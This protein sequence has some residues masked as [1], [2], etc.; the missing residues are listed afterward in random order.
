M[1]R[2]PR[3]THLLPCFFLFLGA[4][5]P[6]PPATPQKNKAHTASA[7][8][9]GGGGAAVQKPA[10]AP[11]PPVPGPQS[12][13]A[14]G[15]G[16]VLVTLGD[17]DR[18]VAQSLFF[19]PDRVLLSPRPSV[20]ERIK[21]AT[22]RQVQTVQRLLE[23]A[24]LLQE[25][26][27][28]GLLPSLEAL[29]AMIARDP[30]LSRFLHTPI[31]T[32]KGAPTGHTLESLG[33]SRADLHD[34]AKRRWIRVQMGQALTKE[35]TPEEVWGAWQREQERDRV[36]LI[37]LSNLPRS[38]EIDHMVESQPRA[39][40]AHYEAHSA[41]YRIPPVATVTIWRMPK[42]AAKKEE[43]QNGELTASRRRLKQAH[44]ALLEGS[45]SIDTLTTELG[46]TKLEDLAIT[47]PEDR[48]L[49]AKGA[50]ALPF[51][52]S[53]GAPKGDYLWKISHIKPSA[54]LPLSRPLAREIAS[55]LLRQSAAYPSMEALVLRARVILKAF[56]SPKGSS[57][58]SVVAAARRA[59]APMGQAVSQIA[60]HSI[61]LRGGGFIPGVG[62]SPEFSEAIFA[63]P[64]VGAIVG[65]EVKP[66]QVWLAKV[67][68]RER[69]SRQ[70]FA[71]QEARFR[72]G[73]LEQVAPDIVELRMPGW[74]E[75]YDLHLDL[76]PL[77]QKYPPKPK[78]Q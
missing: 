1:P 46:L 41:T 36:L 21:Y 71:K 32:T 13:L 27:Q 4:C 42:E 48:S 2:C 53:L 7:T 52:L 25:A 22:I 74:K 35:I 9:E 37:S 28:R 63:A 6:P 70:A 47:P 45:A 12:P 72:K 14:W 15:K 23:D 60:V 30:N 66:Q 62:S 75:T 3:F 33:F 24:V 61:G 58:Q 73:Y 43:A 44:A 17:F 50:Q 77:K 69:A 49:F 40:K 26:Q 29:E 51:G 18:A 78:V 55:E 56:D 20:P 54:P 10:L 68:G 76:E 59:F 5:T 38:E 57:D 31:T 39:I 16:G 65:P 11:T 67:I 8:A 34:V 64:K 19:A